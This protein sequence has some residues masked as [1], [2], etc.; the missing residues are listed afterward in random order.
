MIK[1]KAPDGS[2]VQFADGTDDATIVAVMQKSYPPPSA[3]VQEPAGGGG[4]PLG[5]VGEYLAGRMDTSVARGGAVKR[6]DDIVR[7]GA[8]A[9]TF[10][11]AD[12][13]AAAADEAIGIGDY[14]TNVAAERARDESIPM[15]DRLIGGIGGAALGGVSA[16]ARGLAKWAGKSFP[17]LAGTGAAGG[18]AYGSGGSTEGNR[19]QGAGIGA[20]VGAALPVALPLIAGGVRKAITPF[21]SQLSGNEQNL[22]RAAQQAGINLTPGQATGSPAL[23]TM[24][25]RFAQFPLTAKAQNKIYG[26]QRGTFNRRVLE[27]A[28]I[29]ADDAGP[30]VIDDAFRQIGQEF[31]DLAARSQIKVDQRLFDDL[32]AVAEKYGRRLP[33]D[34]SNV[35]KSYMD[36]VQ[37]LNA[38]FR[39]GQN[40]I[41]PGAEY[42]TLS[43]DIKTA[44]RKA[45]P[46]LQDALYG[47]ADKLDDALQRSGGKA[48]RGD[49]REVRNRYRNL[50]TVDS[51]MSGGTQADRA[52]GNIP[53]SGLRTAVKQS[54]KRGYARGRGDLNELSR[55]GDFLG[56]TVPKDSGTAQN[57]LMQQLLSGGIGAGGAGAAGIA[58]GADPATMAALMAG[59]FVLPKGV[60][61]AYNSRLLQKYF[62]NQALPRNIRP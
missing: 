13:I 57:M 47:L 50:L 52:A 37:T 24:E 55:I 19:L 44:A 38:S 42:Q 3:D 11:Y 41:I 31:D 17:R 46:D 32:D 43:S 62:K 14:K 39:G 49:W 22:A 61:K 28:G 54:D 9:L 25:G 4:N 7:S 40:P 48:L 20:G 45:R 12:E 29:N 27:K 10:G 21:S 56:S 6:I 15:Q 23:R 34:I 5:A 2:I 16:P 8:D 59:G 36:D 33:S 60:Q 51:A 35:F 18:A 53:F 1:I 26:G 30:E 58:A